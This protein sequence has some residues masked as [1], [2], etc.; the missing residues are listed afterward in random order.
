M[1]KS[2]FLENGLLAHILNNANIANV[3]D[4]TGLRGSTAA[5]DLYVALHTADPTEAVTMTSSN[6]TSYT[7]YARQSVARDGTGWTV[8]NDTATLQANLDFP[9]C[10]A[11][12]GG[13][14]THFSLTT[15]VSGD[16]ELL[17]IGTVTPN[18]TMAEG[19]IP[20]LTTSTSITED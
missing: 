4:A 13:A 18:I 9:T 8:T 10:G 15:A 17:Y 2:N 20:R 1:S 19:V 16:T 12:P 14:I 11:T 7:N 3:G 6:E 5:G